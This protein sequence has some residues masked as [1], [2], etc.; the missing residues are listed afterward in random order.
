VDTVISTNEINGL[1]QV[2]E[3]EIN[4]RNDHCPNSRLDFGKKVSMLMN[5]KV[6]SAHATS[7][8][9]QPRKSS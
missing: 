9:N 4:A 5:V 7:L 1:M 3:G 6:S 8:R 2:G